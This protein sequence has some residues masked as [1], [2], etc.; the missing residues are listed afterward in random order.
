MSAAI[1]KFP[2]RRDGR[3]VVIVNSKADLIEQAVRIAGEQG[4]NDRDIAH[5]VSEMQNGDTQDATEIFEAD[6][7]DVVAVRWA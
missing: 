1:L 2:D 4:W 7:A 6:F 5:L 3:Q